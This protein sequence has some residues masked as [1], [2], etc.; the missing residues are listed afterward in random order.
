[1]KKLITKLISASL[2]AAMLIMTVPRG[3]YAPRVRAESS[4]TYTKTLY[5][6]KGSLNYGYVMAPEGD[7]K[8]PAVVFFHGLGTPNENLSNSIM[9][10]M[11][12]WVNAGY[13]QPVIFVSPYIERTKRYNNQ[14][15]D[16]RVYV[17]N[18]FSSVLKQMENGTL[19]DRIDTSKAFSVAGFSMGGAASLYVGSKFRDKFPNV[20]SLSPALQYLYYDDKN[21]KEEG[22]ALSDD[23]TRDFGYASK[24]QN[25]HL[26]FSCSYTEANHAHYQYVDYFNKRFGKKN[27]FQ[28][29]IFPSGNHDFTQ[30]SRGLFCFLYF[31]QHDQLPDEDTIRAALGSAAVGTVKLPSDDSSDDIQI[32]SQ[33]INAS[34]ATT[35]KTT[36]KAAT[37]TTKKPTTTTTK[38]TTTTTKKP[39]STTTKATTTT[40]K[41]PTTTTTKAT[42][43]TTK[44]TTTTTKATTTTKPTTTAPVTTAVTTTTTAKPVRYMLGDVDGNGEINA[45]DASQIL[46]H[47]ALISTSKKGIFNKLQELAADV[48]GDGQINPVD[49]SPVLAY[50][51]F[52]STIIEVFLSFEDYVSSRWNDIANNS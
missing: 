27:N 30:L 18:E 42:T 26:L 32:I 28:N 4:V 33:V 14:N 1:M 51:A 44:P 22:W 2:A 29:H 36:T 52:A 45:V 23:A 49:V 9:S 40:T 13:L 20:G 35:T 38:A 16:F 47:Y 12:S 31:V 15:E 39:T 17:R 8:L 25:P 11:T 48:N 7:E 19:C 3:I 21:Q 5:G 34:L 10:K 6:E 43:T 24:S 46:K 50:Y 41:K 37:T